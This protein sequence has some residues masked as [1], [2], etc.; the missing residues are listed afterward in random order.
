MKVSGI[1]ACCLDDAGLMHRSIPA[2][3]L[4]CHAKI[5]VH[6]DA[7]AHPHSHPHIRLHRLLSADGNSACKSFSLRLVGAVTMRRN[8]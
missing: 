2:K 6:V 1:V 5:G 3:G 7:D 4:V 8:G